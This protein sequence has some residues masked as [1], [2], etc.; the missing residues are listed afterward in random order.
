MLKIANNILR[1]VRYEDLLAAPLELGKEIV[2]FY[3]FSFDEKISNFFKRKTKQQQFHWIQ[4]MK[5]EKVK[6]I[7]KVCM[8]ALELWGYKEVNDKD[9]FL[10]NFKPV[11]PF[12][13]FS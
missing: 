6:K 11:L 10:N 7:Q 8:E 1:V 5:F 3:G 13:K 9:E 12:T 4:E 2:N